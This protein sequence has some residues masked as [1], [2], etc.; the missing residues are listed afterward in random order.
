MAGGTESTMIVLPALAEIVNA[1]VSP[2]IVVST[3]W[4]KALMSSP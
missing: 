1:L 2:R 4:P 3:G